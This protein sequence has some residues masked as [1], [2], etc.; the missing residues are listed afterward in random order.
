M[1]EKI[2]FALIGAGSIAPYHARA[3]LA[4]KNAE[5]VAVRSSSKERAENFARKFNIKYYTDYDELLKDKDIDA[6]D[7]VGKNYMHAELGMKAA[8]AGKHVLVEKPMDISLERA[9]ALI[10][11]CKA[12][13]VKLSVIFQ[14]RFDKTTVMLKKLVQQEKFGKIFLVKA[15]SKKYRT[16]AY[17][18]SSEWRGKKQFAGGGVLIHQAIHVIDLLQWIVGDV[19]SV[20]GSTAT[21]SHKIEGEDVGVGLLKFKNGA[22]GIIEG[23]TSVCANMPEKI[24]IHGTK[25]SIIVE[26]N[27]L[28]TRITYLNFGNNSLKSRFYYFLLSK[29]YSL[30]PMRA[31]SFKAQIEDFAAAIQKDT[32]PFVSGESAKKSL[33][34]I[35]ALYKSSETGKEVRLE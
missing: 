13:K 20:K 6:V 30:V 16:Q 31:G 35:L 19:D 22:L 10:N 33:G 17:F 15:S 14:R 28:G 18:D 5:L 12:S 34:I 26:G 3:I 11:A 1:S 23:T 9:Q 4:A 21:L 25:G 8:L 2:R 7:I 29:F 27:K 32:A 24:E